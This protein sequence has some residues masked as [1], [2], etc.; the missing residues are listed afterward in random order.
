VFDELGIVRAYELATGQHV[1]AIERGGNVAVLCPSRAHAD[2]RPSAHLSLA[3]SCWTCR[4]CGAG[5]GIGDLIIAAGH[6]TTRAGA[7]RWLEEKLERAG[8]GSS[9]PARRRR[10]TRSD[11]SRLV[12]GEIAAIVTRET[13]REHPGADVTVVSRHVT[14]ARKRVAERYGSSIDASLLRQLTARVPLR[15]W[16]AEPHCTREPLWKLFVA[17]A[18]EER[19]WRCDVDARTVAR[20]AKTNP[21]LALAIIDDAARMLHEHARASA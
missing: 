15:W 1:D 12:D 20:F 7:A 21:R 10:L 9:R 8:R 17:R 14:Q 4:S 3:R 2:S 16:E 18:C 13:E 6:A 19:A 5:G 11:V